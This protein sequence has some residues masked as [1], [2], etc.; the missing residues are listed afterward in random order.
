[1]FNYKLLK[2]FLVITGILNCTNSEQRMKNNL[3]KYVPADFS[4]HDLIFTAPVNRW[5]EALP[6]GNGMQGILVWGDG[7]PLKLSL[8]RA[9]LWDARPVKEW[10]SPDY[11]YQTMRKWVAEKRIDDLHRLYDLPYGRDPAPTKIPAGR[12]EIQFPENCKVRGSRLALTQAMAQVDLTT[13]VQIRIFQHAV[14]PVGILTISGIKKLPEL[15]LVAPAFGGNIETGQKHN[16][17]NTGDLARLGYPAP[18]RKTTETGQAFEQQGWGDFRFAIALKWKQTGAE[19]W[20]A[21]WSIS[22]SNETKTPLKLAEQRAAQALEQGFERLAVSHQTWWAQFWGQ[23]RVSVPNRLVERQW[24]LDTY[25]F[26]AAARRGA[27][28]ITL[29]AVWT[30]DEGKIP[31]W[32]GDYHHD[33]NTELSYWPC[34]SGN[35]LEEG[36][37]FL[38]WLWATLPEARKYTQH[39]FG[40]PGICVPMTAD[41]E[42]KQIGGWHQYTHSATIAAWLSQHFYWHWRFS[43]DR[44]FLRER[45]YPYLKEA[46]VFLAAITEKDAAGQRFLPL[47]S[48]PEIF[49]NRIE[50]W[51]PSTSNYDLALMRWHFCATAELARELG[52]K[53]EAKRWQSV[54][55]EF[56]DFSFSADDGR[57]LVAPNLP[58]RETHRHFSHLMAIHPLGIFRWENGDRDQKIIQAALEEL[59]RLGTDL[60]TGY[61]FSWLANLAARG[62]DGDRAE[63]ALEIFAKAFCSPNSFHLNGDQTKSGYSRFTYRPFTLE[64]NMAAPAGIQEMLLQSYGGIIRIFPAIPETWQDVGFYQLRAQGAFLVSAK[65]QA[66]HLQQLEIFSE[67][68]GTLRVEKL[69]NIDDYSVKL[70]KARQDVSGK[71]V[72]LFECEPGGSVKFSRKEG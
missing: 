51:L 28:P 71:N 42:G 29:Q 48:S 2:Y 35:H 32:K 55:A 20:Q 30:A 58:L 37:G 52:L 72:L 69:F 6:L 10:E 44:D 17:L 21:A 22:S 41:I 19:S 4:Q 9:D 3:T 56:P 15:K 59:E 47:S 61:S 8:D 11:N 5:D 26:G 24:F 39:F 68:G 45:A 49:D 40:K 66:G 27:P 31:P 38:D 16:A 54:L 1:M 60:W 57:L 65:K 14:E 63:Q 13:G 25:K 43:M 12:I 70:R 23:A 7:K 50:A 64:G 53:D 62:K 34:Y 36:L 67:K 18:T 33:L 46:A